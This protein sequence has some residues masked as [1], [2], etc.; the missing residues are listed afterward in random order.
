MS[1]VSKVWW[2]LV[3][4]LEGWRVNNLS[5]STFHS[6]PIGIKSSALPGCHL[7]PPG[8]C[9]KSQI[10]FPM[11][12]GVLPESQVIKGAVASESS[13]VGLEFLWLLECRHYAQCQNPAFLL[14]KGG[15]L[16]KPAMRWWW[17][18]DLSNEHAA[19]DQEAGRVE[20]IWE[21]YQFG[22]IDLWNITF[23]GS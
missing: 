11:V 14:G 16:K 10:S 7:A 19:K 21:V 23:T 5:A 12:H 18:L 13:Q 1:V 20:Q 3:A 4:G 22:L 17:K 6:F 2:F 9:W 15:W 8:S